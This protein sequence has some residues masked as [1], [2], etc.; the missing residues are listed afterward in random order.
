MLTSSPLGSISLLPS[1]F[2][3]F[4]VFIFS[5]SLLFHF[6]Y[7]S[8]FPAKWSNFDNCAQVS[9]PPGGEGA[10]LR[11]G[12]PLWSVSTKVNGL[13]KAWAA[14]ISIL[15][16]AMFLP[17][18][19]I[20]QEMDITCH[21]HHLRRREPPV[22]RKRGSRPRSHGQGHHRPCWH[23]EGSHRHHC[24]LLDSRLEGESDSKRNFRWCTSHKI[25]SWSYQGFN[26]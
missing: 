1:R 18:F 4:Y 14:G 26:S 10:W 20:S 22:R 6:C 8:L 7:I 19:R 12:K 2:C 11:G 25:R 3:H 9:L 16:I 24:H 13:K 17:T 15:G 21:H 5:I 23:H